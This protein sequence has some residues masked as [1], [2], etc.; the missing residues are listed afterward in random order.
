MTETDCERFRFFRVLPSAVLL[1]HSAALDG[2]RFRVV[3]A[4]SCPA[5]T[6]KATL[7]YPILQ[8][9]VVRLTRTL[10]SNPLARP[11]TSNIVY[12]FL[13]NAAVTEIVV[14]KRCI[15]AE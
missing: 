9:H 13:S 5:A 2:R 4:Q 8:P 7:F 10:T 15:G 14:P 1:E 11:S 3:G 12:L 6:W